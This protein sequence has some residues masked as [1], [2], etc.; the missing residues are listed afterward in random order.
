MNPISPVEARARH[1]DTIPAEIV[2]IINELLAERVHKNY[3]IITQAELTELVTKAGFSEEDFIGRGWIDFE[4]GY[5]AR[6]WRV[7]F[8]RADGGAAHW[9]F[10]PQAAG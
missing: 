2:G 8:R 1:I 7:E 9:R 10:T 4:A 5:R 3:I 6:G